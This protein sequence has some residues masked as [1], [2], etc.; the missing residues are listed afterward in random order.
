VTP[1]S[2]VDELL[3]DADEG[4]V[5]LDAGN[6]VY[7]LTHER[8]RAD[9]WAEYDPERARQALE[10]VAGMFRSIDVDRWIAQECEEREQGS[11]P[12]DVRPLG[13]RR[14]TAGGVAIR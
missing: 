14:P 9:I 11:R 2:T 12:T 1:E 6:A 13:T 5:R 8:G 4:P 7:R 3:V 10:D